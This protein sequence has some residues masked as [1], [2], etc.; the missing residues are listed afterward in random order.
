[1]KQANSAEE[2]RWV[3]VFTTYSATTRACVRGKSRL[4]RQ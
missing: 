4:P 1:V 2:T 3:Q